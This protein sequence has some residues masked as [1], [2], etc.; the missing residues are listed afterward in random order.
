MYNELALCT[1]QYEPAQFYLFYA[2]KEQIYD[3]FKFQT[4]FTNYE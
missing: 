1:T 4:I 3:K 2:Q